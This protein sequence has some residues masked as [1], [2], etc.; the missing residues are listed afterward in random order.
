[1]AS[2]SV[3]EIVSRAYYALRDTR[4]PVFIGAA[5]MGLNIVLSFV[6]ATLF[7]RAGWW[8][9]GGLALSNTVAT[10]LEMIGL[11]WLMRRRLGGLDLARLWDGVWRAGIASALMG[12]ALIGWLA[13]TSNLSVWIVGIGGVVLGGIIFGI[14]AY[15]LGCPETRLLPTLVRERVKTNHEDTK[16]RGKT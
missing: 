14:A 10:T 5:A 2:H 4:T 8:P 3:V 9:H 16:A 1:L 6:F 13:L 7:T 15:L 11:G 12:A